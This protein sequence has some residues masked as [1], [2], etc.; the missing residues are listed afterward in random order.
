MSLSFVSSAVLSSTDGISHN[1]ETE[2]SSKELDAVR[3]SNN[4]N[5]MNNKPLFEQLRI[6]QLEQD[7]LNAEAERARMRGTLAL[8]ED[9][10]AHLNALSRHKM[11]SE[12]QNRV[13]LEQEMALFRAAKEE[14]RSGHIILDDDDHY[15]DTGHDDRYGNAKESKEIT[16]LPVKAPAVATFIPKILGKRRRNAGLESPLDQGLDSTKHEKKQAVA[17]EPSQQEESTTNGALQHLL[18]AYDSSS[19][20]SDDDENEEA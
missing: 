11:E 7:E 19:S 16:K 13:E 5:S 2:V 10:V 15:D 20:S 1:E 12:L 8:D 17:A 9:D 3:R 14:R 6:N 18:G 4:N